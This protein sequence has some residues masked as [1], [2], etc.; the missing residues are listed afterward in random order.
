MKNGR[1]D[2]YIIE[3]GKTAR[4]YP[5]K[6]VILT[7]VRLAAGRSGMKVITWHRLD[8]RTKMKEHKKKGSHE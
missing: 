8:S 3:L 1:N 4:F 7:P 5:S 2:R 6:M